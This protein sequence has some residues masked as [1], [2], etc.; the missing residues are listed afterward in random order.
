MKW[1]A[2]AALLAGCRASRAPAHPL[3]TRT[4]YLILLSRGATWTLPAE[5]ATGRRDGERWSI[6]QT[7]RSTMTCRV[8]D[9]RQLGDADVSRVTCDAPHAGLLVAGTWVATP[10]G[11][12]HPHVPIDDPDELALLGN[13]ELLIAAIPVEREHSHAL[14]YA[15]ESLEAF[16]HEGSWCVRRSTSAG[17]E[18]R[19][20]TL[21]F[22]AK[23][24]TGGS[25]VVVSGTEWQRVRFGSA[26]EDP[27]DPSQDPSEDTGASE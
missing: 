26:P 23:T 15:Q 21:C 17:T 6:V 12:Y 14:G 24:V 7:R 3:P 20:Y 2:V 13:D 10:A 22:D 19:A 27:D 9:S 11:L 1:L 18:R 5:E 25:E 4:P 16:G 8:A